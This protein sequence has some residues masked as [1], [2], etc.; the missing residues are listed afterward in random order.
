[1]KYLNRHL[2]IILI[3]V[4]SILSI[5]AEQTL[6]VANDGYRYY[7][8]SQFGKGN[9]LRSY[10]GATILSQSIEV[11]G[12]HYCE[13]TGMFMFMHSKG[14]G[15][16]ST[17]GTMLIRPGKYKDA[18]PISSPEGY[19]WILVR[20]S[21]GL[22]GACDKYGNEIIPPKYYKVAYLTKNKKL[23]VRKTK[24]SSFVAY[25]TPNPSTSS[26]AQSTSASTSTIK[27]K[28]PKPKNKRE[29]YSDGSY[30]D[31]TYNDNGTV[32]TT[33]YKN[34]NICHARKVCNL[35]GGAGGS[36][37][38]FGTYRTYHICR[39]C[40]GDGK[41]KYCYGTGMSVFT[42]TYNPNSN[43]TIGKDL[44]TGNVVTSEDCHDHNSSSNSSSNSNGGKTAICTKC[45]GTGLDP[46][47]TSSSG[48]GGWIG[49][50]HDGKSK[51]KYCGKYESHWHD[52]CPRCNAPK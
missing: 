41:C 15:V 37:S 44:W 49:I 20:N 36:W 40:G 47:P 32:T 29:T 48:V 50:F 6:R 22:E 34:C 27:D 26:T 30:A 28:I 23:G 31:I 25:S 14:W 4:T 9:G 38:G 43:T 16:V 17:D 24:D 13:N 12:T 21:N 33:T 8:L 46:T 39:S 52:K 5:K 18:T 42:S 3:S 11:L 7:E 35:C 10:N 45:N 1:M 2:L 19:I 51:C